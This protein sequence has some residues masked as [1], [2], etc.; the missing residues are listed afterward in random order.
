MNEHTP[1]DLEVLIPGYIL[2]ELDDSQRALVDAAVA[3]DPEYRRLFEDQRETLALL[4][5][6]LAR[7]VATSA[8]S[9]PAPS[10]RARATCRWRKR[11]P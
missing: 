7:P 11:R 3:R 10:P 8:E 5:R 2:G 1:S 4:E 6:A 9:T